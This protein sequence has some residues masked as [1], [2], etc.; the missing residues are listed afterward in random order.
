MPSEPD[1]TKR[2]WRLQFRLST[3][4]LLVTV[5]AIVCAWVVDHRQ[6]RDAITKEAGKV[7]SLE[8]T[9]MDRENQA[10]AASLRVE[11]FEQRYKQRLFIRSTFDEVTR[12]PFDITRA[13][14]AP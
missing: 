7:Q 6:L 1:K 2:W 8:Q 3:A 9:V 13:V 11:M 5:I 12:R 14:P 10:R 4:I